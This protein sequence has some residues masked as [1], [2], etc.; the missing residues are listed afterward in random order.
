VL[1][2][3]DH[4]S[5]RNAGFGGNVDVLTWTGWGLTQ[6]ATF[7]LVIIA[8][9]IAADI[10]V[11]ASGRRLELR[12]VLLLGLG[13]AG[14]ATLGAITQK[15][16]LL[17]WEGSFGSD[18]GTKIGDLL[19]YLLFSALPVV[20]PLAVLAACGKALSSGKPAKASPAALSA[21]VLGLLLILLGEAAHLL[22]GVVDLQLADTTYEEG[23]ALLVLGGGL[24]VGLA[25]I[26]FWGPKL[27]GR[28]LADAPT[29]GI[30]F[31]GALGVALAGVPMLIA[32]FQGQ[33]A[34]AA[35]GFDYE[36]TPQG[37]NAITA[38]GLILIS[39]AVLGF[40]ILAVQGFTS[41]V[42]AG[43]DPWDG[44]TLEW[45]TSSPAP[46]D[47]FAETPRVASAEP[48]LDLKPS[49]NA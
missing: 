21:A 20:G 41:G 11:T 42:A 3:V 2:A 22:T 10:V 49:R 25:G 1:V 44:Q 26:V 27:W 16:Q 38:A 30:A 43:D 34:L 48:L 31:L 17:P 36:L 40:A 15:L 45:A 33:P 32:G 37:L 19:P 18:P 4:R 12:P 23:S 46:A 39:L 14:T 6:P 35:G 9:G 24:L 8:L 7:V 13:V 5:G 28:K 29:L 47:N